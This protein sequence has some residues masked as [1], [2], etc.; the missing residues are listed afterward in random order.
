MLIVEAVALLA[1]GVVVIVKVVTGSPSSVVYAV[2]AGLMA[3]GTGLVLVALARALRRCRAWAF[4]PV[5]V[6][7]GL[8]LPVGY[9]LAVQ[10]GQWQY[11]G[12]VLL[13][14]LAEL[15]LLVSPSSRRA[16]GPGSQR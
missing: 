9:S 5:I 4:V 2:T 7:Q 1:L 11:G 10:A 13:L 3:M 15:V 12:P 16:I 8:A 14:A 6:L